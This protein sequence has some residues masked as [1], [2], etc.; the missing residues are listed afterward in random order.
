MIY[1]IVFA[2]LHVSV[3]LVISLFEPILVCKIADSERRNCRLTMLWYRLRDSQS[4]PVMGTGLSLQY[5][6]CAGL[7]KV[8][9]LPRH[10]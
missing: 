10:L 2:S 6:I 9:L 8:Y 5:F 3:R 7:R 4:I 1:S